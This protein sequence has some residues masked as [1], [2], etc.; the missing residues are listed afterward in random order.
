ME[1]KRIQVKAVLTE[2]C[3]HED[4]LTLHSLSYVFHIHFTY[5]HDL[6]LLVSVERLRRGGW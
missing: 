6:E 4:V 3:N 5:L 2:S 1:A